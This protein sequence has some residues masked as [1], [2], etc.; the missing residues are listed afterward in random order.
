MLGPVA[1]SED[2]TFTTA[3][4]VPEL[5]ETRFDDIGETSASLRWKT[6]L[7]TKSVVE[8]INTETGKSTVVDNPSYLKDHLFNAENLEFA[9]PYTIKITATDSDGNS[10]K[11]YTLPFN[12]VISAEPAK[13]SNVR[14]TTSL[15]PERVETAQ[16]IISWKTDKPSTSRVFFAEGTSMGLNQSTPVDNNLV[17]DHIVITTAL[18]PGTVYK[19][20]VASSDSGG[21]VSTSEAYTVLTPKPKGSVIDIIFKNLEGTFGFLRGK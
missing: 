10:S 11:P 12:T 16:T 4:L 14:I 8:V 2:A 6:E 21:N 7:P 20:N 3:S 1:L 15:I 5:L 17:R 18:R 9:T 19:I 13:I